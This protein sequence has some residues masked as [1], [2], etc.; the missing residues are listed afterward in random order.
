M[1]E[2]S[3][4]GAEAPASADPD[5]VWGRSPQGVSVNEVSSGDAEAPASADPDGVWGRSP[6][7]VSVNEVSSGGGVGGLPGAPVTRLVG[8]Q[9]VPCEGDGVVIEG[10]AV[11]IDGAGRIVAVGPEAAIGPPPATVHRLG[12]LLMPGLVNAHAHTPMTLVRSAG[13][14]LPLQRWLSEG[15]WPREGRMGP[16]DAWWGMSLGSAEMLAAGVTTSCEMYLFEQE[17]VDAVTASGARLVITPGVIAALLRGGDV[18]DRIAEIAAFHQTNHRPDQR[19]SV[20]FAPHSVY[21]L[22]PEQCGE[23]ARH[24][25]AT[26][27]LFHIHLEETE[28]ERQL[29]RERYGMTATRALAEAGALEPRVVAA[30]GVWLD[31]DDRR[32]L[33][34]AG[35]AVAHC[36]QSNLKLGSGIAPVADLLAAGVGVGV[37]TDG[38]ASNDDLDLWE[39]LKLAP[40][41]AR[42]V[43]RDPRAMDATT[44]LDLAT[45]SA[46]RA[47]GLDDVGALVPGFW[48]DVIRVDTDQP[49]FSPGLDLLTHL[50]FAGSARFVTDV[51]VSGERVVDGG[52]VR[53]VDVARCR[54]EVTVR[55]RRLAG[56]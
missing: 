48:A 52:E 6:Q 19:I 14:G 51:W 27:A 12:G 40:L 24:A 20:G 42:G 31:A 9:V 30:H 45:R 49:A 5:G 56:G 22:T 39:E 53:T 23:I 2:V 37:G 54:H 18:G 33:A 8:D 41:L 21:D 55:G 36:P 35:A 25:A 47:I 44:A 26:G 7:G 32:L 17:I 13:D 15:V 11:D 38:A 28:A 3:S 34:E 1:N 16:D 4:G 29:V 46:A 10:G 43:S 50:V